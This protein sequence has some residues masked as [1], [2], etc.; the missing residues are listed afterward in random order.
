MSLRLSIM[1]PAIFVMSWGCSAW[2]PTESG[3]MVKL[4]AAKMGRSSVGLE[5]ATVTIP[6]DHPELLSEILLQLDEQSVSPEQRATLARHG[7]RVG[8]L[9]T[10]IPEP[11][12]LLLLEAAD[13]RKHPTALNQAY[14]DELKFVQCRRSKPITTDIWSL[15][16]VKFSMPASGTKSERHYDQAQCRLKMV[17]HRKDG[18]ASIRLT[19]EIASGPVK[20]Q[21]VVQDLDFHLEAGRD[22]EAF[23]ELGVELQLQSGEVLVMTSHDWPEDSLGRAV[24]GTAGFQKV[25]LVR[26]AQMQIDD[27]FAAVDD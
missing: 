22:V 1:L 23:D 3:G 9:G 2:Q 24:F 5:V 20:Q 4:P 8:T 7:M 26:L 17:A 25:F 16:E 15:R 6:A 10:S 21:Y 12:N 13:R 14:A 18:G 19:P 11:I 27:L